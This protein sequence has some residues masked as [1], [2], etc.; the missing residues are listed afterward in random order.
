MG[1]LGLRLR[2]Y[3]KH[4]KPGSAMNARRWRVNLLPLH[5]L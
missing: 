1:A 3:R 4:V 5:V 2:G